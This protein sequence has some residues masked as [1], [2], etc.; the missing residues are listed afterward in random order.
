MKYQTRVVEDIRY[1]GRLKADRRLFVVE[2]RCKYGPGWWGSWKTLGKFD[3]EG[4]AVDY[5]RTVCALPRI[6]WEA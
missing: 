6:V 2:R 4:D 5:A 3:S 1:D